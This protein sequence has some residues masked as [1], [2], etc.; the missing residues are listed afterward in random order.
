M[1]ANDLTGCISL[2]N[3]IEVVKVDEGPLCV[4][5]STRDFGSVSSLNIFPNPARD[6][7]TISYEG[8]NTNN[9]NLQLVNV[10]GQ[11]LNTS[12]LNQ[13]NDNIEMNISTY[14]PGYYMIR[15]SNNNGVS[16]HKFVITK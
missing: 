12:I 4:T 7:I 1:N 6:H 14:S 16:T 15:I 3:S 8:L 9:G 13:V 10:T 5:S 2:S 11:V